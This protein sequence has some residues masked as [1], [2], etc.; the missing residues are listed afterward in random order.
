MTIRR[1][2]FRP[3]RPAPVLRLAV[4][5]LSC[6]SACS[7]LSLAGSRSIDVPVIASGVALSSGTNLQA[8]ARLIDVGGETGNG[9]SSAGATPPG[10]PARVPAN[11][12]D[13]DGLTDEQE[14]ALGTDPQNP[15]TD[16]DGLRDGFEVLHGF[17]PL[18]AGEGVQDPDSD[19][20]D[21]IGEQAAGT[22]PHDSDTDD[23]GLLDAA[24]VQAGTNP[25]D[26]D[27]DHD[28]RVD[29]VDNCPLTANQIGRAHV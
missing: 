11:D 16:G 6:L 8:P 22:D 15:D 2:R 3:E 26:P 25:L 23:D 29:P 27:T 10:D 20:L 13:G 9:T 5:L 12:A 18:H 28:G 4:A 21:N 7:L 1:S 24:E 14:A 17:N 19:G